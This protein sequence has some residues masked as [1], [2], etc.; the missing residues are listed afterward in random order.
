MIIILGPYV[1]TGKPRGR[2]AGPDGPKSRPAPTGNP[3][4]RKPGF[5][6]VKKDGRGAH[7]RKQKT[8]DNK[9]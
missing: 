6:V 7:F 5:V 1:P 3:R 8:E 2:P 4:G 9:A